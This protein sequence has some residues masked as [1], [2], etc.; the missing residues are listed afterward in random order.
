LEEGEVWKKQFT[1]A[2]EIS[3]EMNTIYRDP[4]EDAP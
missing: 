2:S 4:F 3:E 1:A